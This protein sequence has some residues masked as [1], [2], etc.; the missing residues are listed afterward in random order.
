M[1]IT[2]LISTSLLV[3]ALPSLKLSAK[4]AAARA[5]LKQHQQRRNREGPTDQRPRREEAQRK[6]DRPDRNS[7]SDPARRLVGDVRAAT[8]WIAANQPQTASRQAAQAMPPATRIIADRPRTRTPTLQ[9]RVTRPAAAEVRTN[10]DPSQC[11]QRGASQCRHRMTHM[12][13]VERPDVAKLHRRHPGILRIESGEPCRLRRKRSRNLLRLPPANNQKRN[14]E[15][16]APANLNSGQQRA[17]EDP[18]HLADQRL[19]SAQRSAMMPSGLT[20]PPG[21]PACPAPRSP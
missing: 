12:R 11:A 6:K 9:T 3:N 13:L 8:H 10:H 16:P 19:G 5:L 15:D 17:L 18:T 21:S 4:A 14:A 1:P 2:R 7:P 20:S